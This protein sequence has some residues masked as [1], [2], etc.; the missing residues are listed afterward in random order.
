MLVAM[1]VL[2]P[3][4]LEQPPFLAPGSFF[5]LS[6]LP[7]HYFFTTR[8][9]NIAKKIHVWDLGKRINKSGAT[10]VVGCPWRISS[11]SPTKC[12]TFSPM[13]EM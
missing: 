5:C 8:L 4:C 1:F 10:L 11:L 9:L 3:M 13:T 6:L 7:K 2:V 12:P